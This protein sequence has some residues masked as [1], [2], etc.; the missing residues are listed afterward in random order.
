[1]L[2]DRYYFKCKLGNRVI[3]KPEYMFDVEAMRKHP[4]YDEVDANGNAVA[5]HAYEQVQRPLM[6]PAVDP[7]VKPAVKAK[8]K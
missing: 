7:G 5:P 6:Q 1:M 2:N 4:E 3:Y 8:R